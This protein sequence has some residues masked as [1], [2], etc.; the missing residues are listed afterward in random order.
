MSVSTRLRAWCGALL[1][2]GACSQAPEPEQALSALLK[3]LAAGRGDKVFDGLSEKSQ[4]ELL[5]RAR[6]RGEKLDDSPARLIYEIG[7]LTLVRQPKRTFVSEPGEH[8]SIVTVEVAGG[9]TAKLAMVEEN[10]RWKLDLFTS[11]EPFPEYGVGPGATSTR[12]A[13]AP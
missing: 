13:T 12:T 4:K 11:L 5:R 2:I 6:A 1:V 8:R 7:E 3:N 9:E 10:G